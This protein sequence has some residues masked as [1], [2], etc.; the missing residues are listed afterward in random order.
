MEID[1]ATAARLAEI[2]R[3]LSGIGLSIPGSV[4][5]RIGPCGK[6]SCSCHGDPPKL[7][8]PYIS[9]TR[10]VNA[11]TVTRLLSEAQLR[12]YQEYFDSSRRIKE[13]VRE[14]EALSVEV[15]DRDPR[16]KKS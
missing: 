4:T 10:K 2:A 7:H 1:D 12:E 9:W 14:L 5:T 8:G 6:P 16:W 15:I 3:E 11:K 13:L